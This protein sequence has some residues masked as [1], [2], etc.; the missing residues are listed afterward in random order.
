[1]GA[2]PGGWKCKVANGDCNEYSCKGYCKRHYA[3]ARLGMAED[4]ISAP[5]RESD[6][7][8]CNINNNDCTGPQ[9]AR[10]LCQFHYNRLMRGHG[11][12]SAPKNHH[13]RRNADGTMKKCEFDGCHND[14]R[15]SGLCVSHLAQKRAGKDLTP[16][17]PRGTRCA[18]AWCDSTIGQQSRTGLCTKHANQANRFSLMPDELCALIDDDMCDNEGCPNPGRYID[19]DHSCCGYR[20][21]PK[22]RTS[23]GRCIRGVL[24]N[25]CNTSLGL[26][27][28]DSGR[29]LGLAEYLK[30]IGA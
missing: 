11:D 9:F 25:H 2:P 19:H 10:G 21:G 15:H 3:R 28:E 13:R 5:F 4:E 26:L 24:C 20:Q 14:V 1:M 12:I 6:R 17:R 16:I 23:C 8:P 29:I 27:G 18:V 22:W 7:G 30:N